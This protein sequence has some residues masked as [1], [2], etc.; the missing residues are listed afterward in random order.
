M[1]IDRVEGKPTMNKT[2]LV[3]GSVT[4]E[5]YKPVRLECIAEGHKPKIVR[6]TIAELFSDNED[7]VRFYGSDEGEL[8]YWSPEFNEIYKAACEE[9]DGTTLDR[10]AEK[11]LATYG[12]IAAI[13][14]DQP[15][16]D[17]WGFNLEVAGVMLKERG[18]TRWVVVNG[19]A[20]FID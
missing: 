17:D 6:V 11:H 8:K 10:L 20:E 16:Y 12:D 4:A 1:H 7:L 5:E 18:Y 15:S 14:M 19:H 2:I 13:V 9:K 3:I